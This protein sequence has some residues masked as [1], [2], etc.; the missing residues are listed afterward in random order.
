VDAAH[1]LDQPPFRQL[2]D[3][4]QNELAWVKVSGAERV[5]SVGPP[6][7]DAIPFAQA[8]IAAAP[9]RVLW[10]T[11]FP[12]PNVKW[13]PDD[14]ALVDLFARITQDPALRHRVLVD[15]PTRLAWSDAAGSR[16][17]AATRGRHPATDPAQFPPTELQR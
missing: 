5:S 14:G 1:G 15:N 11:D 13:M 9:E 17:P 2:L 16:E 12:H 4:M 3:L 8:L 6:F 7:T 10:G